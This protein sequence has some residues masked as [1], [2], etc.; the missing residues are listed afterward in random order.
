M[1]HV[2]SAREGEFELK[3]SFICLLYNPVIPFRA[4][5]NTGPAGVEG[6]WAE[7]FCHLS[8]LHFYNPV[9]PFRAMAH[10]GPAGGEFDLFEHRSIA[11]VYFIAGILGVSGNAVI[12]R[13]F[14]KY[15][16]ISGVRSRTHVQ[17]AFGNI[18]VVVGAF[19]G[20]LSSIFG[21]WL[22]GE[23]G[24]QLYGF[25]TYT[26]GMIATTMA[27]VQCVE[28]YYAQNNSEYDKNGGN[29]FLCVLAW[30]YSLSVAVAPLVGWNSYT[31][32]AS[33]TACG[34]NHMVDD[35]SHKSFFIALP[36]I[37]TV[38]MMFAISAVRSAILKNDGP[39]AV[40]PAH[41]QDWFRD[42]QLNWIAVANLLTM[43]VGFAPYFY[44]SVWSVRYPGRQMTMLASVTS[45]LVAKLSTLFTP[46]VYCIGS[47]KFRA[48]FAASIFGEEAP[49]TFNA[50]RK[51]E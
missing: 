26:G 42:Y 43:C 41:A 27:L 5:T 2:G 18:L 40:C 36:F 19:A 7:D 39:D 30:L 10:V 37:T 50:D 6:V 51:S 38:L 1:E 4:M 13:I 17:F 48:A 31:A 3:I 29:G 21:R 44:F 45:P 8:H 11:V 9:I 49:R 23:T 22:L 47:R 16:P 28:R 35:W 12:I 46:I 15:N 33:G 32:E 20:G 34:L 14:S 25:V 24:C